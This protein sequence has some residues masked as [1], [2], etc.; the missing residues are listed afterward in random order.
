MRTTHTVGRYALW[1]A[2][3]TDEASFC[4]AE[5]AEAPENRARAAAVER[6]RPHGAAFCLSYVV[7][8]SND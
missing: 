6:R 2:R 1:S 3:S 7:V 4:C 8:V 5:A